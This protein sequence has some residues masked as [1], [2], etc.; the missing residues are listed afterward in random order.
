MIFFQLCDTVTLPQL[1]EIFAV[2]LVSLSHIRLMYI[3]F[4]S[5]SK[6]LLAFICYCKYFQDWD[7]YSYQI[8]HI[9]ILIFEV[10]WKGWGKK[11]PSDFSGK[12]LLKNA[13][14]FHSYLYC[15]WT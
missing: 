5:I 1:A 9:V 11:P 7:Y 8:K 15:V 6:I 14:S 2:I 3:Y 12:N 4:K 13:H 10:E